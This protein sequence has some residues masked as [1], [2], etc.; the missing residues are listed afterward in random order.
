MDQRDEEDSIV[1]Q[2]GF[3][4]TNTDNLN[5]NKFEPYNGFGI[6]DRAFGCVLKISVYDS[7]TDGVNDRTRIIE[8]FGLWLVNQMWSCILSITTSKIIII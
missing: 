2:R 1:D 7:T 6:L 5:G 3:K 4:S 8:F